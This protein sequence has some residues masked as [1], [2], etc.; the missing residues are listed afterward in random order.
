MASAI[1]PRARYSYCDVPDGMVV[2]K[3]IPKVPSP[4][5]SK[6]CKE[7]LEKIKQWDRTYRDST[8]QLSV[9]AKST[10]DNPG[11][12]TLSAFGQRKLSNNAASL[13][14]LTER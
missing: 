11:T 2:L 3:E 14:D 1:L 10:K 5:A 9:R 12:M 6:G 13:E 4:V 7:D 8:R